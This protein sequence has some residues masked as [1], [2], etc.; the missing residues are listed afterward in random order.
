MQVLHEYCQRQKRPRPVYAAVESHGATSF[1][2]RCVVRDAKDRRKD[3]SF[4]PEQAA[5]SP[6]DAKHCAALLALYYVEPTRPLERVLPEPYRTLWRTLAASRPTTTQSTPVDAVPEATQP[7]PTTLTMDR[8]FASQQALDAARRVRTHAHAQRTRAQEHKAQSQGLKAVTMSASCR[9]LIETMLENVRARETLTTLAEDPPV[10]VDDVRPDPDVRAEKKIVDHALAQL[11]FPSSQMHQALD[12]CP[13]R[14]DEAVDDHVA[15]LLD[16]L[17]LHVPEHALPQRFN[18]QGTQLEVE[19]VGPPSARSVALVHR[20][21]QFGYARDDVVAVAT[22]V[23]G[24][25]ADA[26]G[27]GPLVC[28]LLERLFPHVKAYFALPEAA[29]AAAPDDIRAH[30]LLALRQDELLALEAIYDDHVTIQTLAHETPTQLVSVDVSPALQV[31]VVLGSTSRYPFELPLL[32]VTSRDAPA[33][34]HLLLATGHALQRCVHALGAPMLFDLVSAIEAYFQN[35]GTVVDP[36]SSSP[37]QLLKRPARRERVYDQPKNA[38]STCTTRKLYDQDRR[39]PPRPRN[40]DAERRLSRALLERRHEKTKDPAFLQR[41]D[42][43]ATLPASQ[44]AARILQAV[45]E[46]PVVL[47]CG[48]TGCGKSTQVPQVLLDAWIERGNGGACEIVC[49]QPRRLAAMGVASRVAYERA[50]DVGDVVGYH[51]RTDAQR[52]C[53]TRLLFCTTGILLRRFLSDRTLAGVSHVVVDEVHERTVETDFLLS[54]LR[55]VLVHRRDLRVV[56]MS[57]T[58]DPE[59]FVSYFASVSACP[60]V[61]IPGRTFPVDCYYLDAILAQT[62]YNVPRSLLKKQLA[63][64]SSPESSADSNAPSA[65]LAA[66]IDDSM[67][68]YDLVVQLICSLVTTA[69]RAPGAILVFLPGIA[70]IERV[71]HLLRQRGA[72][73]L[74]ALPLHSSLARADQARVFASA[75]HGTTKVIVS[76]NVAETSLTVNDVTVVIDTGRVKTVVYDPRTRRSQLVETWASRAACDQRKGRAGRV[77]AG[78]CYRVFPRDRWDALE[79]HAVPEIH[80]VSLGP[81]CLQIATLGLGS[82]HTF[83][84]TAMMDPP[85]QDAIDAA[86]DELLAIG[87]YES[88]QDHVQLTP[89]GQH[90]ARLPLD[91]RIGKL[92][93]YGALLRCLE[94]VATIAA[95]LASRSPFC[96]DAASRRTHAKWKHDVGTKVQSDHLVLWH[97]VQQ[98][99]AVRGATQQRSWCRAHGVSFETLETIREL[100]QQYL[101]HLEAMGFYARSATSSYN[102]HSNVPRIIK[103]ALCAGLYANVVQVVYPAQKYF[104]AAHGVVE[105]ERDAKDVRYFVRTPVCADKPVARADKPVARERVWLHPSSCNFAAS[106]YD[107]PWLLYSDLVQTSKLYVRETTSVS[108]YALLLFGGELVVQHAENLVLIDGFVRLHAPAR[109]GVL[110]KAMREQVDR[111]LLEKLADPELEI[112]ETE[113]VRVMCHLLKSEGMYASD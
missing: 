79:A 32:A 4:C 54:I 109:I 22:D 44:H 83:L 57:A 55:E 56:L 42:A 50:E 25:E 98:Y 26:S 60:V 21:M 34:R 84:A 58:M 95:C 10:V 52:S 66:R 105:D 68:L 102:V 106:S 29:P 24:S 113:V 103:A 40:V 76:T 33:S 15:R 30:E 17:C 8:P 63:T 6:D 90:L 96:T 46:H 67:I 13:R 3:L 78:T 9:A 35:S 85:A 14:A 97:M 61:T 43:R 91:A 94:P 1:R 7:L 38:P 20:L 12:A 110:M 73:H 2:M 65:T 86:M 16:W 104:H 62:E 47:V 59:R 27:F 71:L 36:P 37:L 77:A 108:P 41:L 72:P 101:E 88:R 48:A 107:S 5:R 70:E 45:A 64:A 53:T 18:P 93:V 100:T 19:V 82:S 23:D 111:L 81:L 87:A 80:R 99:H 49:T 74:W 51:I 28:R 11:G 75:P 69:R 89:L 39:K 92:L 31:H 112:A